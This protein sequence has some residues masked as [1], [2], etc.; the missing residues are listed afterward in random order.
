AIATRVEPVGRDVV[1]VG[2]GAIRRA[3][4]AVVDAI[5]A[6]VEAVL[7]PV[8]ALVEP[9]LDA[10][11]APVGTLAGLSPGLRGARQQPQGQEH[12]TAFHRG[13]PSPRK[14]ESSGADNGASLTPVDCAA[15]AA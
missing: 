2:L 4:E 13:L 8:T 5:A 10:V 15:P 14:S 12:C 6:T 7:D 11:T 1:T 3:I 9:V